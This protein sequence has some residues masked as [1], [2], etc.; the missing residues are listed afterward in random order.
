MI[1][2]WVVLPIL[3]RVEIIVALWVVISRR[4]VVDER[5]MAVLGSQYR[6]SIEGRP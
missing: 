6:T 4:I 5:R 3:R 1:K 2:S